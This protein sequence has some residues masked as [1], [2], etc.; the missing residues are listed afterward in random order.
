[1][2]PAPIAVDDVAT[3]AEDTPLTGNVL[4]NDRDPDGDALRVDPVPVA[5]P[6]HGRLDLHPDGT[7]TYIPDADFHGADAFTYALIDSD[8]GRSTATVHLT[9][10]SVNDAP[11]ANADPLTLPANTAG[12]GRIVASDRDGDPLTFRLTEGPANGTLT[13]SADGSYTY[14][15]HAAYSG[16]DHFTVE[17]SDGNGGLARVTVAITVTPNPIQVPPA[18]YVPGLAPPV[19]DDRP[20]RSP[21]EPPVSP[22]AAEGIVLPTVAHIDPLGSVSEVVLADGAVVA[23]VNGVAHLHG[24]VI[25]P[26]HP[27]MLEEGERI[28]RLAWERFD[29]MP[30]GDTPW[31]SPRPY[32][33]R[34]LGVS[35]GADEL[36]WGA[37]DLM[38]EAIRRPDTLSINL[39]G[40]ASH[41][42]SVAEIRL[43]GHD[44]AP[45]PDW[46]ESDGL[47]GFW[48]RPPAGTGIVRFEL[49]IVLQD[50]RIVRRALSVDAE[51]GEIRALPKVAQS[52][53]RKPAAGRAADMLQRTE[54]P[55]FS[56]QLATLDKR[57]NHDMALIERALTR[58][59]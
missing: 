17:V 15:P 47:G 56:A 46:I 14:R 28:A 9:V 27:V 6:A 29:R 33:G 51:T 5:G 13:L 21:F 30:I 12:A 38:V 1:V 3:T 37:S 49:E 42:S 57:P 43:L 40:Y 11:V 59:G 55:L 39:H 7:F 52:T 31:F 44:G 24:T 54:A 26:D 50:G 36:G 2:N 16:P 8:G 34:S 4:T 48:G 22:V 53:E 23:A 32:L 20:A 19:L 25:L 58:S 10:G 35:L 41:L 45:P 18:I